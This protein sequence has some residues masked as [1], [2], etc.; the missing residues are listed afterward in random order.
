LTTLFDGCTF[1]PTR[2]NPRLQGLNERKSC[3]HFARLAPLT[4]YFG[5]VIYRKVLCKVGA[6]SLIGYSP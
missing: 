4:I 6:G 3:I 2:G 1:I 5:Q